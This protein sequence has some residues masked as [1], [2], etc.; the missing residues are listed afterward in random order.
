MGMP[1]F[2][3]GASLY[4]TS[5]QYSSSAVPAQ[6]GEVILQQALVSRLP[7]SISVPCVG[8]N[9]PSP[10]PQ[11]G[12][13][14]GFPA[15]PGTS[16]AQ[17]CIQKYT[18]ALGNC[19]YNCK[20]AYPSAGQNTQ[21][22]NCLTGCETAYGYS[23]SSSCWSI[24]DCNGRC[25]NIF[26]NAQNCGRCGHICPA[27]AICTSGSCHCGSGR[28]LCR[29]GGVEICVNLNIDANNCGSCG[30]VCAT[31]YC[32]GGR[33]V[34]VGT[35]LNNCGSCGH[36]CPPG[37]A[38]SHSTCV[39]GTCGFACNAGFTLCNNACVA[40][41]SDANNCGSCGHVCPHPINSQSTSCIN[42]TCDFTCNPGFTKCGQGCSNLSNDA[43]N[44]GACSVKCGHNEKCCS[45]RCTNIETKNNC[46]DCNNACSH[47]LMCIERQ[48]QCSPGLT[49]CSDDPSRGNDGIGGCVD[50]QT[51]PRFC[52]YC[53]VWCG[54]GQVC[55]NGTCK[56]S[57]APFTDCGSGICKDTQTDPENCGKC[58]VLCPPFHQCVNGQCTCSTPCGTDGADCCN[59]A[60]SVCQNGQCVCALGQEACGGGCCPQGTCCDDKTCLLSSDDTCCKRG[61]GSSCIHPDVCC[62]D[63]ISCA[64]SL[65]SC[66]QRH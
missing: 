64:G 6:A 27:N 10:L 9:C 62:P 34:D 25:V 53:D 46:G 4:R 66:P 18:Q 11:V 21:Y 43:S 19:S 13:V 49:F 59:P 20:L 2:T 8:P 37:P 48:C 30:R 22:Q 16:C 24:Q 28:T 47:N 54:R 31:G 51:D 17:L 56:H 57:C 61:D 50:L 45:G 3:A 15:V 32:C 1:G 65:Q 38:N 58:G 44:C 29:L 63:G 14:D 5:R 33:C 7:A 55:V 60:V 12:Q 42:A 40:L 26:S 41:N 36:V 35:D 23:A 52:G 39:N